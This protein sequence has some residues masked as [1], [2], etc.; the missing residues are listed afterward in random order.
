MVI[1]MRDD[2]GSQE[3][4]ACQSSKKWL[5]SG[6]LLSVEQKGILMDCIG[7]VTEEQKSK[8]S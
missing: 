3:V 2:G 5:D 1:Q 8:M 6:G 7:V 4:A